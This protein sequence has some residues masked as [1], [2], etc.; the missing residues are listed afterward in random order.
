[1]PNARLVRRQR[2]GMRPAGVLLVILLPHVREER[3]R[4]PT[5]GLGLVVG[6]RGELINAPEGR[7]LKRTEEHVN[8]HRVPRLA[9]ADLP[10]PD[11]AGVD[12]QEGTQVGAGEAEGLASTPQADGGKGKHVLLLNFGE[13]L[14]PSGPAFPERNDLIAGKIIGSKIPSN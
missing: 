14:L 10:G 3:G 12:A 11:D 4:E 6:A 5:H 7:V 8:A 13:L 9:F 1:M 2:Q